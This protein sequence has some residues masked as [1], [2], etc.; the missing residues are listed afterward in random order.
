MSRKTYRVAESLA[1]R[2]EGRSSNTTKT[3]SQNSTE[4][5]T[6][7]AAPHTPHTPPH[8]PSHTPT[9]THSHTLHPTHP[10]PPTV[11]KFVEKSR[12]RTGHCH[13]GR[14]G[15]VCLTS[16]VLRDVRAVSLCSIGSVEPQPQTD[17]ELLSAP[18]E[19]PESVIKVDSL[20]CHA[21]ERNKN[22]L[23]TLEQ[24]CAC[25]QFTQDVT[26]AVQESTRARRERTRRPHTPH[27]PT[28]PH[29]RT[30]N[31][32]RGTHPAREDANGRQAGRGHNKPAP[33]TTTRRSSQRSRFL[34]SQVSSGT[35][36]REKS[37]Q[38]FLAVGDASRTAGSLAWTRSLQRHLRRQWWASGVGGCRTCHSSPVVGDSADRFG[39]V[40]PLSL[41]SAAICVRYL[42]YCISTCLTTTARGANWKITYQSLEVSNSRAK[43]IVVH[44]EDAIRATSNVSSDGPSAV[45]AN[46]VRPHPHHFTAD[47]RVASRRPSQERTP[48]SGFQGSSVHL[49]EYNS[50]VFPF[51]S[52]QAH[53]SV[54]SC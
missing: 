28:Q 39:L 12:R 50:A 16:L 11:T 34:H 6:N 15:A 5:P 22:V 49:P 8:A 43:S 44:R 31:T 9:H 21:N 46:P 42:A 32:S 37:R 3:L 54:C 2:S 19:P 24:R 20:A 13:V 47:A 36:H 35:S 51:A 14:S 38:P 40:Q 53:D 52:G 41:V 10:H 1:R 48:S 27:T 7:D 45:G 18:C 29:A 26:Y 17:T 25:K 33:P 4:I 23:K 30:H